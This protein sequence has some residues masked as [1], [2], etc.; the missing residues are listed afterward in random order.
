MSTRS[1]IGIHNADDSITGIYCHWSGQP[2]QNG[3]VLLLS[4]NNETAAKR[5]ATSGRLSAIG[6]KPADSSI[7]SYKNIKEMIEAQPQEDFDYY[8][9][10]SAGEWICADTDD[11][12]FMGIEKAQQVYNDKVAKR[13]AEYNN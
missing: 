5:L 6:D 7:Y 1:F 10:F 2:T 13:K 9:L 3:A 11:M 12:Q 8:Y 4:Y